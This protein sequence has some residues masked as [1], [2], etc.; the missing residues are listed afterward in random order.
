MA[1]VS[2]SEQVNQGTELAKKEVQYAGGAAKRTG[3]SAA[4]GISKNAAKGAG[5]GGKTLFSLIP[6]PWNFIIL[7][8]LIALLLLIVIVSQ[9]NIS[10]SFRRTARVNAVYES[11]R[12]NR[13][14]NSDD[15]IASIYMKGTAVEDTVEL[16]EVIHKS[17]NDDMAQLDAAVANA[18]RTKAGQ[19]GKSGEN[20]DVD[21]S[22][23]H[24]KKEGADSGSVGYDAP[25]ES[26]FTT[27]GVS[28]SS[29][30]VIEGACA[31]AE[32][33][34]KD[35]T[36]HY[37]SGKAAHHNGCYFCQTQPAVKQKLI[38]GDKTYCCNPFVHAAFAH[39][40]GE[41]TM[42]KTCKA[43]G[44]YG[45]QQGKGYD[46]SPLFKKMGKPK[47]NKLQKGDVLCYDFGHVALYMGDGKIAE[48]S[49]GDDNRKNSTKW[50]DSIHVTT[51][52]GSYDRVYRYIGNGGG[53]RQVPGTAGSSLSAAGA[54]STE[55]ERIVQEALKYVGKVRYV[56]GGTSLTN[57]IDCVGFVWRIYN[58][59]G[60]KDVDAH[61]SRHGRSIGTNIK[62]ALPGDII[63]YGGH[64]AIYMGNNKVVHSNSPNNIG[65]TTDRYTVGGSIND[66]RRIVD[67]GTLA[68]MPEKSYDSITT[69]KT[70]SKSD[71]KRVNTPTQP[72]WTAQSFALVDGHFFI[73]EVCG[74]RYDA[75]GGYFLEC[76][77]TGKLIRRSDH[78]SFRHGQGLA[79]C[80][81]DKTF[82]SSTTGFTGNNRVLYR[83]D[84]NDF[85]L[86][87]SKNVNTGA[88][89]VGYDRVNNQF[90]V[91]S[92]STNINIFD[93]TFSQKKKSISRKRDESPSSLSPQDLTFHNGVVYKCIWNRSGPNYIDM[94][95]A[96]TGNYLG[97]YDVPYD[98]LESVEIDETGQLILLMNCSQPYM[99]FTGIKVPTGAAA[100]QE[101][102]I[103]TKLDLDILAAYNLS[104]SNTSLYMN[105]KTV[106]DKKQDWL[107]SN[108]YRDV[109]GKKVPLYWY[110]KN[111]GMINYKKDLTKKLGKI[112]KGSY[113]QHTAP[114]ETVTTDTNVQKKDSWNLILV[115]SSNAIPDDYKVDTQAVRNGIVDKRIAK[116]LEK[117][118]SDCEK[119]GHE[120][121]LISWYR[122]N[123]EQ[124]NLYNNAV[125]KNDT[126]LPG[127]SEHELGLAVDII[128]GKN[129]DWSGDPLVDKQAELPAQKWL[130]KHCQ[131]Y[132]FILR[133]PKG[134]QDITGIIWEPWH[135]RYVGKDAAREIM[136]K[137]ITLEEFLGAGKAGSSSGTLNI[138]K[139][140]DKHFYHVI[141]SGKPEA[142]STADGTKY[143]L[144]VTIKQAEVDELMEPLFGLKPS[145]TYINT[146]GI[147]E[148][149]KSSYTITKGKKKKKKKTTKKGT[150]SNL[151][152]ALTLSDNT[153][154]TLFG[155]LHAVQNPFLYNP[156]QQMDGFGNLALGLVNVSCCYPEQ[157]A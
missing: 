151:E 125:N 107:D 35:D 27:G 142:I 116:S 3:R 108:T 59:C 32:A 40:G 53:M 48:A 124:K 81:A 96:S 23:Q 13:P 136:K 147:R 10:S 118:L 148:E 128:D 12:Y 156:M 111:R 43:G 67:A 47:V 152:A 101:G 49:G 72:G 102:G 155:Q 68:Q 153:G 131:D 37:G 129:Q 82:Y 123:E 8:I 36:F 58:A 121:D 28:R 73:Q 44:S 109:T 141:V 110:G 75:S 90:A 137:G 106:Q 6:P 18:V 20:V 86:K 104:L 9:G 25:V 132:G 22:I 55:G 2:E 88:A 103:T 70:I 93:P 5:E 33:I 89:S 51:N 126:A 46:V 38:D 77:K 45:F 92:L 146:T 84:R 95:S 78:L 99:Q 74:G 14:N 154:R 143:I 127:H 76:D 105:K 119:A 138:E 83:I 61:L 65:V 19:L 16:V 112:F 31:W 7:G 157:L 85:T 80:T 114:T 145:G 17:Q 60:Y 21:L 69:I 91:C 34:A 144:P 66:I 4:K 133:Y 29:Q 30:D 79:Y 57:G 130:M 100:G 52:I 15:R 149:A 39:G 117:M 50:N 11:N 56:H 97:S 24:A 120:P 140:S 71:G 54:V 62:D 122:T 42:L 26:Q 113:E 41:P 1:Y 150:A 64:V 87:K 135:Y 139:T 98:E 115:N 94:Y 134:K 63:D